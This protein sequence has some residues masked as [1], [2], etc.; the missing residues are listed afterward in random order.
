MPA[1]RCW[2]VICSIYPLLL[3]PFLSFLCQDQ[4]ENHLGPYVLDPH[5]QSHIVMPDMFMV[6]PGNVIAAHAEER[7]RVIV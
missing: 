6:S 1:V 4:A 3:N 7:Q 2:L 5:H